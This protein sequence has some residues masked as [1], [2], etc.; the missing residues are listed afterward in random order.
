MHEM[1]CCASDRA[2]PRRRG[3][4]GHL[5]A[6]LPQHLTMEPHQ[7]LRHKTVGDAYGATTRPSGITASCGLVGCGSKTRPCRAPCG[8]ATQR[9]DPCGAQVPMCTPETATLQLALA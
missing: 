7:G 5:T 2:R 9:G 6:C 1:V 8:Q 3:R 4:E